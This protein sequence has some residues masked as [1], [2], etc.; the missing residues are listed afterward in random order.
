MNLIINIKNNAIREILAKKSLHALNEIKK[1][2]IRNKRLISSQKKL[3]NFF[4]EFFEAIYFVKKEKNNNNNNRDNNSDDNNN[5]SESESE[6]KSLNDSESKCVDANHDNNNK[7]EDEDEDEIKNINNHFKT[8]DESAPLEEQINL[9][10]IMDDISRYW[11]MSYY[12]D[13]KD[14]N[15]RIF[16]LKYLFLV[17]ELDEKLFEKIFGHTFV[18]LANKVINTTNKQ[19]RQIIINDIRKNK[20]K[21]YE[22]DG[23]HNYMIESSSKR[24]DIINAAKIILKFNEAIQ[25]DED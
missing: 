3:I 20:D 16:N 19:E 7:D 8:I 22:H 18:T 6:S 10:R 2:K 12:D 24:I 4:N 15:L 13:D 9:L 14:L 1:T 5:V 23:F 11:H 21:L 17:N 25:L